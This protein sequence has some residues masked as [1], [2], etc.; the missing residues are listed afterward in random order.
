LATLVD[1]VDDDDAVRD[2]MH[3][4]LDSFGYTVREHSSAETFLGL[5]GSKCD[6]LLVDQHMPGMT[7]LALLEK[8]RE[9][10]DQTP[11]L[12]ITGRSDSL[13]EPRA[14]ALGVRVLRKPVNEDQLMLFIEDARRACA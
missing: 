13:L 11:A 2:S 12:M 7:G 6:C 4:L 1:I 5:S 14:A 3:A 9:Q 8:M 10:G